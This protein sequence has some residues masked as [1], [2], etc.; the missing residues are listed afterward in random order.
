M[1]RIAAISGAAIVFLVAMTAAG[2]GPP[3]PD[4][5]ARVKQF[6]RNRELIEVMIAGGL[7]MA[8]EKDALR[9][10]DQCNELARRL[11]GEVHDAIDAG[12]ND[13]AIE[14]G[15]HL[16]AMLLRGVAAN[17]AA[18]GA[19]TG[20]SRPTEPELRR[21]RQDALDLVAPVERLF[22]GVHPEQEELRRVLVAV[23]NA[24]LRVDQAQGRAAEAR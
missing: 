6:A 21:V 2:S 8:V 15:G 18:A 10:A 7:K 11:A 5:P 3:G 20:A 19:L 24:R 13:R 22:E 9:R 14:M 12:E 23:H 4:E 17:L 1:K 16:E